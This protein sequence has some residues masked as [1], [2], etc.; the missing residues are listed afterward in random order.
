MSGG[1]TGFVSGFILRAIR[2]GGYSGIF[3]LMTLESIGAPIPSEIV[4][5]FAG[6]LV[7]QQRM[8]LWL[9]ASVGALAC[10][11]GSAIAYELA[12]WGGRPLIERWGR[13][14]LLTPDDLGR[15][16]RFFERFGGRAV[17]IGRLLPVVRGLISYPAGVAR[18]NRLSFHLYTFIGSFPWCLALAAIGMALGRAWAGDPRLHAYFHWG[19][20]VV[21]A[22]CL[23]VLARFVWRRTVGRRR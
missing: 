4:L 21:I 6:F 8:N 19:A 7:S 22:G 5:P 3:G 1:F 2:F 20:W 11:A 17:L 23:G 16:E 10:N 18:M 14:L 15:A 13:Y 12:R 9:A